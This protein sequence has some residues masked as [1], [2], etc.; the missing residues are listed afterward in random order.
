MTLHGPVGMSTLPRSTHCLPRVQLPG[1]ESLD[2]LDSPVRLHAWL[3]HPA[4]LS[5]REDLK[6]DLTTGRPVC[7]DKVLLHTWEHIVIQGP[8]QDEQRRQDDRL[9]ALQDALRVGLKNALPGVEIEFAILD[10]GRALHL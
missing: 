9:P 2:P 6:I 1:D 5:A 7:L 10:Q 4:V 8:L 3:M